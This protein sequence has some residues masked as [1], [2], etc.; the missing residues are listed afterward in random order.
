[1]S[2]IWQRIKSFVLDTTLQKPQQQK[3]VGDFIWLN[4]IL[5]MI[6][7]SL[8]GDKNTL[9]GGE[10]LRFRVGAIDGG[11]SPDGETAAV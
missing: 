1:M 11:P 4:K 6:L 2:V 8:A 10:G 3:K 9:N 5:I 7:F